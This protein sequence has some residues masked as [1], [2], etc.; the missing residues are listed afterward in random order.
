[1]GCSSSVGMSIG[2]IGGDKDDVVEVGDGGAVD[3]V[4]WVLRVMY[5]VP[6]DED[7]EP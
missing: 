4:W 7:D 3:V 5:G 2:D 6:E 1:M